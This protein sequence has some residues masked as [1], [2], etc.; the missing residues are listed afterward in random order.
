MKI[1]NLLDREGNQVTPKTHIQ[2]VYFTDGV[3]IS[4]FISRGDDGNLEVTGTA[5]KVSNPLT[6][7]R[8]GRSLGTFDGSK[9]V[10]IDIDTSDLVK[11]SD[12]LI[13]QCV[14]N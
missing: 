11:E 3:P 5:T 12:V 2:S 14:L 6:V 10:T 13:L 9:A 8:D 1:V 4:S 7:S